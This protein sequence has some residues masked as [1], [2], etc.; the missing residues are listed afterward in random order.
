MSMVNDH[1]VSH[2]NTVQTAKSWYA[3]SD[4]PP[5]ARGIVR[6]LHGDACFITMLAARGLTVGAELSMLRNS[7]HVPLLIMVRDTRLALGRSEAAWIEVEVSATGENH[8][9]D[10]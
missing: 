4:M 9:P 6:D 2:N 8:E 3:L 5:G 10:R 1:S 7:G